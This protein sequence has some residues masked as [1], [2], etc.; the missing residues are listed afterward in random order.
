M[1]KNLLVVVL[2]ACFGVVLLGSTAL[3]AEKWLGTWKLNT[4]KS[5]W[6]PGPGPK[7][8]T[9][10]YKSTPKGIQQ[11]SETVDADGKASHGAY[12]SKFDGASVPWKGNPN[13]D[14]ATAKKVDDSNFENVWMK[15]GKATITSKAVVSE[16]GKTLTITQTG[17]DA[18]GA[19][20]NNTVVYDRQ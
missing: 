13:A 17:T 10:K 8:Q 15:A 16:D 2:M 11:N 6:D 20:V 3:G 19:T 4:E 18:K 1:R 12:L 7:S 9:L 5:T 14:T